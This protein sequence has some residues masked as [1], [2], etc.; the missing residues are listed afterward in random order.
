M[1]VTIGYGIGL[2][3]GSMGN[4]YN[5]LCKKFIVPKLSIYSS[6]ICNLISLGGTFKLHV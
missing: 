4:A 6:N 3:Q 2:S 5:A 1:Y